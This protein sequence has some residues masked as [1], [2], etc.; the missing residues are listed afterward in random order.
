MLMPFED[1]FNDLVKRYYFALVQFQ[2]VNTVN[3]VSF[4]VFFIQKRC[5]LLEHATS[6][7]EKSAGFSNSYKT[8]ANAMK[9]LQIFF[10]SR[11]VLL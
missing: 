11:H 3:T 7:S 6:F 2:Q 8:R 5:G 9:G 10:N 1:L 4:L